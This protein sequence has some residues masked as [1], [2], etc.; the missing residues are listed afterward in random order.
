MK[1]ILQNILNIQQ[2]LISKHQNLRNIANKLPTDEQILDFK[3][4]LDSLEIDGGNDILPST[5]R[6]NFYKCI[7]VDST[8]Q[9]WSGNKAILTDGVYS[10]EENI[11]EGLTYTSVIPAVGKI[12]SADA[13]VCVKSLYVG[14]DPNTLFL[15]DV[16]N[17]VDKTGNFDVTA[18][19]EFTRS[20]GLFGNRLEF[21]SI[22]CLE[23]SSNTVSFGGTEDYT[24]QL[25][26]TRIGD[27]EYPP[28]FSLPDCQVHGGWDGLSL[29]MWQ[30]GNGTKEILYNSYET[31]RQT[32]HIAFSRRSSD[33]KWKFW[34][35]G[36]VVSDWK[37][38]SDSPNVPLSE[39]AIGNWNIN[40]NNGF[41]IEEYRISSGI[42]YTTDT[43][44][45]PTRPLN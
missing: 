34:I 45:V 19:G 44:D 24:V 38:G 29:S 23:I 16:D 32:K 35:N 28:I 15:L 4:R 40:R 18:H 3:N 21:L 25:F 36:Q 26:Y 39:F 27:G 6:S 8:A 11:T 37:D 12:Y 2:K 13:L 42:R 30:S 33:G 41:A 31:L 1:K 20:V 43:F 22:Q 14:F 5:G 10:F 9:T 7:F 17:M